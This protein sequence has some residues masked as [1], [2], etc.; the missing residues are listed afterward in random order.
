MADYLLIV[1]IFIILMQA[2]AYVYTVNKLVNK[3]MSKNFAE[4]V[5]VTKKESFKPS[6]FTVQLPHEEDLGPLAEFQN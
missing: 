2:V 4:Y 1:L 3:L 6:A 5:Q